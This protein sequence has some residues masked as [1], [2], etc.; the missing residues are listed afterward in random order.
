MFRLPSPSK[1]KPKEEVKVCR[2]SN[3][4]VIMSII[5]EVF[6]DELSSADREDIQQTIELN[7]NE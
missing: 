4:K 2:P 1:L 6:K 5:S 3:K 7:S